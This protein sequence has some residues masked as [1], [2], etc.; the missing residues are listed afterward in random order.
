MSWLYAKLSLLNSP[1]LPKLWRM[2]RARRTLVRLSLLPGLYW[3]MPSCPSSSTCRPNADP[4]EGQKTMY[5]HWF[6]SGYSLTSYTSCSGRGGAI[7]SPVIA[8]RQG[9]PTYKLMR[10]F[11]ISFSTALAAGMMFVA[12]TVANHLHEA[13][14]KQCFTHDW[15]AHQAE[16]H[17]KFCQ[18]YVQQNS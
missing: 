17:I 3:Q 16:A 1:M 9:W 11:F 4:A 13:T 15:P 8:S 12:P 18:E 6:S 5:S 2:I 14:L 7:P 10:I